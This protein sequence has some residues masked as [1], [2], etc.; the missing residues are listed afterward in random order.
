[1]PNQFIGVP[2]WFSWENEGGGVAA[3]SLA[4]DGVQDLVVLMVDSPEG[5]NQGLFRVGRALD[6]AGAITA[7]WTPWIAVPEW[8]SHQ[9]QGA[10]IALADLGNNGGQD[11]VVAMVDAPAGKNRGLFRV[12]RGLDRRRQPHRRLDTVDPGPGLVLRREPGCRRG[13]EAA[14]RSGP[15]R[16][17]CLHGRQPGPSR[18]RPVPDRPWPGCRRHRHQLDAVDRRARLVLLGQPG[19]WGRRHRPAGDGSRDLVVMQVDNAGRAEPGLLPDREEP[20]CRRHPGG[21]LGAV[22]GGAELVLPREPGRR[23]SP[24]PSSAASAS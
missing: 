21:R 24:P 15:A 17:D 18:T 2:D 8:F 5:K 7:G 13:G 20:R 9:N 6:G 4:G 11:L 3:A 19:L 12:G 10:G 23:P 14:R 1:M 22:D 16:P